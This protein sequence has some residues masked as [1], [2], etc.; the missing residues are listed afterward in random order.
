[1]LCQNCQKET[2]T[3]HYRETINGQ[4]KAWH[5]CPT[6]AKA[7]EGFFVQRRNDVFRSV[8]SFFSLAP[9]PV[10]IGT[11]ERHT[12][13]VRPMAAPNRTP[14]ESKEKPLEQMT[15]DELKASLKACIQKEDY[16]KAAVIRDLL[17]KNQP[18]A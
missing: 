5:L 17:K 6:C 13:A 12:Q 3:F 10:S 11:K 7:Q 9:V 8:P 16:E 18:S 2:A 14:A 15:T 4:T 1:M